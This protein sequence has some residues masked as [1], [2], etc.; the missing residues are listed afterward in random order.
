MSETGTRIGFVGP[1][2]APARLSGLLARLGE[3]ARVDVADV[4]AGR[5]ALHQGELELLVIRGEDWPGGDVELLAVPKRPDAADVLLSPVTMAELAAGTPVVVDTELRRALLLA[6]RPDLVPT[7]AAGDASVDAED[8]R[9][10]ASPRVLA[11]ADLE[12][13]AERLE[14]GDWPTAPGQGA[15][16][17]EGRRAVEGGLRRRIDRLDHPTSRLTLRAE[18]AVQAALDAAGAPVERLGA[19]AMLEDGLLFLTARV[20][21]A[22]GSSSLTASHAGYPEDADDAALE[23]AGRVAAELLEGLDGLS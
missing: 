12:T 6:T 7:M 8:A 17:I 13:G 3:H 23:L 5:E 10:A 4:V 19:T 9:G 18:R 15:L 14:L 2:L 21:A 16:V 22:D 1:R 20:V 11:A